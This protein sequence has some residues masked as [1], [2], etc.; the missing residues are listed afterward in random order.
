MLHVLHL[1]IH[2]THT[3]THKH[4]H[5]HRHRHTHTNTQTHTHKHTNTQTHKHT[6]SQTHTQLKR[7]RYVYCTN[8]N[9]RCNENDVYCTNSNEN[10][11][12]KAHT[13]PT[14][15]TC[16]MHTQNDK[17]WLET[18]RFVWFTMIWTC[19]L[20][21]HVFN[22]INHGEKV[23][24]N[25]SCDLRGHGTYQVTQNISEWHQT[26]FE[27]IARNVCDYTKHKRKLKRNG[28]WDLRCHET[29]EMTQNISND[30]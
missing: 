21:R 26:Y 28:S 17:W 1:H 2:H 29:Y 7:K 20:T 16:V 9:N 6:N 5:V 8:E 11:V 23:K 13:K 25:V 30:T 24:R 27:W 12:C 22:H 19:Q 4:T 14:Q 18:M 15:T 10:D 3:H